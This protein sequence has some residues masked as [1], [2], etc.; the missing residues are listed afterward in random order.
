MTSPPV[1]WQFRISHFNEKA[2]WAL[3]WKGLPHVRRSLLPGVHVPRVLWMTRQKKVPVLVVDGHAIADS[4]RIIEAVERLRPDPPLYPTN[5][6]DRR[7][8]LEL[9]D[10]FDEEVGPYMRR[11]AFHEMRR[12]PEVF[13]AFASQAAPEMFARGGRLAGVFGRAMTGARYGARDADAAE[14]AREKVLAGLDRLEAELRPSGYLVGDRFSVADLTAAALFAP[15]VMPPEFPY[16]LPQPLPGPLAR[17]R[18]SIASRPGFR[19]VAETYR[20]HRGRS[21]EIAA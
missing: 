21:A 5:E 13:D 4:S 12:E 17:F 10:W 1:L 3:D 14:R 20:R 11:F 15:L 9:E 8:A 16:E 6:A 18:E 2:R 7:R 19:W